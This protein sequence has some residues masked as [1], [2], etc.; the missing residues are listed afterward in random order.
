MTS[1]E[2]QSTGCSG[3]FKHMMG[4]S[5]SQEAKIFLLLYLIVAN[6]SI[7]KCTCSSIALR[8]DET[9]QS[10]FPSLGNFSKFVIITNRK[11]MISQTG[12]HCW[13]LKHLPH[14]G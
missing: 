5:A 14:K 10:S 11:Q 7:K 9:K 1:T 13:C 3:T 12:V 4:Q 2:C 6:H 8:K